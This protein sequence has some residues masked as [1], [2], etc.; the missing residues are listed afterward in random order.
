MQEGDMVLT[1]HGRYRRVYA[2][3]RAVKP[4]VTVSGQGVPPIRVSAEHPFYTRAASNVWDNKRR[5]YRRTLGEPTWTKA[6]DLRTAGAPMNAAGGDL[7]FWAAP[8]EFPALPIPPVGGRGMSIDDRL[9][10][11]AGRYVGDGWSR[12]GSGRAELVITCGRDEAESLRE[13]LQTWPRVGNRAGADELAWHE[14]ETTTAYQFSTSHH[15]LVEWLRHE[16]GH[17]AAA[18]HFPAWALGMSARMRRALL[19]GY[20]SAD[21]AEMNIK[22]VIVNET[23]TISRRL[24]FSTKALAES[25]GAAAQ[26]YGPRANTT[27]IDGRK[28]TANPTYMVRW[29]FD[30]VRMQHVRDGLH[31]W[32]RVQKVTDRGEAAPVFNISVEED[33]SYIADGIVVHNCKHFSKAKGGRPVKRSIRDL[34]W[35]V[36][37]WAKRARPRV[38]ILENVEEF[39]DWGPLVEREPGK[40][41]PCPERRGA[42]FRH[43]LG[44]LKRL[45]YRAE[46]R[47]LRACDYGAP[48]IRKRFFLIARRDGQK[49]VWPAPMHGAPDDPDVIAGRKLPWR[50]AAEILDFSLPCPSIFMDRE[51]A[52]AF[53]AAT[54]IR[55]NRPLAENTMA[56]I[57]KGIQR[58]VME[59][60]TP[61]VIPVTHAG[62]RRC[63]FI[64]EPLRT[65]TTAQRGEYALVAAHLAKFRGDSG[66]AAIAAPLPTV[67]SNSFLKR[68]GGAPP[69]GVIATF[70]AQHNG[71]M[72]GHDA[73]EPMSTLVRTGST[74]AVV[75][76]GLINL[77]GSD[78]RMSTAAAPLGTVTAG[79][80]H[81]AEVRAFLVKYFGTAVGQGLSEPLHTATAKPR[82]GLVE[83]KGEPF[84]IVDIG[85][86]MLTPRELFQAQGFPDS[87]VIDRGLFRD[88]DGRQDERPLTATAA[89]RMCGNSVC[90]PLAAALAHANCADMAIRAEEQNE[91][92]A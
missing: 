4:L 1:H 77:K 26:V 62:D 70:L 79:G 86:R 46:W 66:G 92:A 18:K 32:T 9:M 5:T 80:W 73:R 12:I 8:A 22:S 82:F 45:G 59:A 11:L 63:H 69:L 36:I 21:G 55:V 72:V 17:G 56:R 88:A 71:G 39:R 33:E 64:G 58:Y 28:V 10:W 50:T 23:N 89:I 27:E 6:A 51:E 29:R 78:R 47:E 40:W 76:A 38:I 3:M 81:H 48:T 24:A 65:V 41:V 7:S 60:A 37:L 87:Y 67:T 90:P 13:R 34:A 91:V 84:E 68:P 20:L 2:T 61:F 49:I 53:H 14:R 42:T 57:A 54:G 16:F 25:L 85:M 35:V 74:Q 83:I 44:E 52:R 43:W 15:G 31:T 75:S 19:D 30:P